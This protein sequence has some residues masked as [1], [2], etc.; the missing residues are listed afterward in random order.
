MEMLPSEKMVVVIG[1]L[2]AVCP[3]VSPGGY[4]GT[5]VFPG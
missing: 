5:D 3:N 2:C 4:V 1:S